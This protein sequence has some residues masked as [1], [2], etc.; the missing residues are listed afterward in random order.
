MEQELGIHFNIGKILQTRFV[1]QTRPQKSFKD[2]M[3]I[4]WLKYKKEEEKK[5]NTT[6]TIFLNRKAV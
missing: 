4:A 2:V 6:D 3:K 1:P 5:R